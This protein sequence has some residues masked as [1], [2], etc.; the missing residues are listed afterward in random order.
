MTSVVVRRTL[1]TSSR[2]SAG[3]GV[4]VVVDVVVVAIV[5]VVVAVVVGE[6]RTLDDSTESLAQ[7]TNPPSP[8]ME[9]PRYT[10]RQQTLPLIVMSLA[11]LSSKRWDRYNAA[12]NLLKK[13]GA[14]LLLVGAVLFFL[15]Q[16]IAGK[17]WV[18]GGVLSP[19]AF[20]VGILGMV[21]G[22]YLLAR[23]TLGSGR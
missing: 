21:G 12:M 2:S 6:T 20:I 23:A 7:L 9:K 3:A 11:D 5:D 10:I 8:T 22:G 4:V 17:I 15:V 14:S 16:P 13:P 1:G 18:I 19:M